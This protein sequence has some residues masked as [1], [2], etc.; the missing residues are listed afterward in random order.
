MTS[1]DG[2]LVTS[3]ESRGSRLVTLVVNLSVTDLFKLFKD[4]LLVLDYKS[5]T[6]AL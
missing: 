5:H 4:I 1:L 6:N 2:T 3:L